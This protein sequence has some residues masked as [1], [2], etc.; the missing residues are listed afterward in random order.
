MASENWHTF[1]TSNIP[2]SACLVNRCSSTHITTK[3][4]LSIRNFTCM[5]LQKLNRFAWFSVPNL[6]KDIITIAVPS[7]DP[8]K[9]LSP[10]ALKFNE[11]I[12]PSCPL[13]VEC[14]FP[15]YKSHNFA[16]WSIEPV[17]HKLLWG[18]KATV[19]TS[20]WWPAKV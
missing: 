18:S 17:A 5:A 10:S 15:V 12:S 11:T 3:L 2:N 14:Y 20:F 13:R 7:K 6:C 16:V 9:I 19:T 1:P 8:V 4:K